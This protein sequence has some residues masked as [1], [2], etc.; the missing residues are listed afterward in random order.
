M[1]KRSHALD[2]PE[3]HRGARDVGSTES[4]PAVG[5]PPSDRGLTALG[6]HEHI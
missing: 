1:A 2:T 3:V 5:V 6:F 4:F